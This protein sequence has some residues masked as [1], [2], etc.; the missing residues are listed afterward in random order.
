MMPLGKLSVRL[1]LGPDFWTFASVALSVA[2]AYL[3]SQRSWGWGLILAI[4]TYSVDGMDGATAR[5]RGTSSL[6]GTVLD[7][8]VD[9]YV[10]FILLGGILLS[11]HLPAWLLYST[12]FGMVM[13]SYVRAKAE[14]TG[15]LASCN[16]G[17]A[18][19]AEKLIL[20]DVGLGLE[21]WFGV[22]GAILWSVILI[23]A[24]SHIT[25]LQRLVYT[26]RQLDP[27]RSNAGSQSQPDMAKG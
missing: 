8:S 9:R 15:G 6:F 7:H 5:A 17:W 4:L 14:S 1:G 22:N 25:F 11:G 3:F 13:A 20:L 12:I 26:R 23:G 18:G 24:I 2:A 27:D 21:A 19:R 10:E 16:V